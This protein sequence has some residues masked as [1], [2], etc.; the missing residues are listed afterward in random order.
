MTG[1]LTI[2]DW[3]EQTFAPNSR[4]HRNTVYNWIKNGDLQTTRIGRKIYIIPD[5]PDD[6]TLLRVADI[7][8]KF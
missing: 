1:L 2:D 3:V 6:D 7:M 4:P 5:A 8:A